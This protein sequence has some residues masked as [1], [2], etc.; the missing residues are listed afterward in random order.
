MFLSVLIVSNNEAI[1][2][3]RSHVFFIHQYVETIMQ[4]RTNLEYM[5]VMRDI[6]GGALS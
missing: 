3:V 1:L 2:N 4:G 5:N 6:Y